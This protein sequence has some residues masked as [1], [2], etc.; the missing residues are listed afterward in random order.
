[1][2]IK[3]HVVGAR[4]HNGKELNY[5]FSSKEIAARYAKFYSGNADA[6]RDPEH[7]GSVHIKADTVSE[8]FAHLVE[9]GQTDFDLANTTIGDSSLRP[10]PSWLLYSQRIGRAT[11]RPAF[12]TDISK[13]REGL[14]HPSADEPTKFVTGSGDSSGVF[15]ATPM[16]FDF[17]EL[18]ARVLSRMLN[19]ESAERISM[20][21]MFKRYGRSS[22]GTLVEGLNNSLVAA[23]SAFSS[24]TPEVKCGCMLCAISDLVEEKHK[25]SSATEPTVKPTDAN[26]Q[27][28]TAEDPAFKANSLLEAEG[29]AEAESESTTVGNEPVLPVKGKSYYVKLSDFAQVQL[30]K[31]KVLYVSDNVVELEFMCRNE[32]YVAAYPLSTKCVKFLE[33]VK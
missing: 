11:R 7:V 22:Y 6:P 10:T 16:S 5:I 33:E 9:T 1:M 24:E 18:E 30:I 26:G 14:N 8:L 20:E 27:Q 21:E 29:Q 17:D 31:A 19:E 25:A 23:M 3:Y 15:R 2:A 32:F 12:S 4:A 13:L 28:Y